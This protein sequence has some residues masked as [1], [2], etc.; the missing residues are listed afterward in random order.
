MPRP[1]FKHRD[2]VYQTLCAQIVREATDLQSLAASAARLLGHP[3][4]SSDPMLGAMLRGFIAER[5]AYLRQARVLA[6]PEQAQDKSQLKKPFEQLGST[7]FPTKARVLKALLSSRHEFEVSLAEYNEADARRA[8]QNIEDLGRRF[9]VH[10]E[11]AVVRDCRQKFEAFVARCER[12]RQQVEQVAAQ[13]VEAARRGEPK[14]ADWLL[15]RLRAIHALTP[16]LLSAERFEAI[17]QQIQRVSQKHAQREARAA[18]IA[19]ERAV[20]DRIKRAGA[21]IYRFHKASAE[22]P[23]ESEEYQ[24]AEA[25]YNAAVEEVRSLDTDWLTGLLLDLETYLDDLHDPEG[26]TE[27]Q[28]DRFIGTVRVA[29]RQLRQEIR[30]ITAARQ[31][32]AP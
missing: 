27:M 26:R 24:R 16:V 25:A 18:L 7:E 2:A 6:H 23:P 4:V 19:R 12:Y 11:A 14:T 9:P 29:L 30:A 8:L 17:A 15:R 3:D 21:A 28:L 20:A 32:E 13:A 22:L 5:E 31:R 1:D 10:V